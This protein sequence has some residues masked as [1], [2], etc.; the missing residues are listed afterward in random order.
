VL[1]RAI[2]PHR[3]GRRWLTALAA[4]SVV[5]GTLIATSSA[6]AVHDLDLFE[7]DKNAIDSPA[8]GADDWNNVYASISADANDTGD[9]DKCIALGAVECAFTADGV[10]TTIFTTGGSKD[11]IDI[12]SWRHTAGSVPDKDEILNA[13]AAKYVASG[14]AR[15]GHQILYFGAD[16]RAQNGSADF[17]FW[18]FRNPVGLN[19]DGT[20]SGTHT[21]TLATPGDILILGT[22]TQGGA[23]TNIRVFRW[24][25]TGGN[26]SGTIQ[27]PDADFQD[28][29]QDPPL[30]NDNGC[31]TVNNGVIPVAWPYTPKSG[32]AG[33]IPSGGFLEGGID[34][35]AIGL[36]GCFSSFV[37]ETRSSPSVT[38]TLKDFVLGNFEVCQT[39]LTTTP[40]DN[41]GTPIG[42]GGISI[43]SGSVQVR[44]SAMLVVNGVSTW[45]G[46]LETFLCGPIATGTC[47]TGGTSVGS[48]AVTQATTQ[49]ILSGPATIT[50]AGRY[51]WRG[52]FT[53]ATNGVPN[54]SDSSEGECFTVNPVTPSIATTASGPVLVGNPIS[55]S[56]TLSGTATQP[57][58]DPV[59]GTIVFRAYGPDDANCSGTAAFTSAT[60]PVSGNG[61]YSSGDFTPSLAGTYRWI[62]TYSG[63][64]PNTNPIAGVCNAANETSVVNPRQPTITTNASGANGVPLGTAISDSATLSGTAAGAGGTITFVAYGPNDAT[65]TT[66]A[67]TSAAIPVNGDG[68]YG[69]GDFTP[70][71]AGTYRWIATYSGDPPNTLGV[72]GVCNADNE[73]SLVI[74]LTPTVATGQFFYPNDAATVTV[75]SGGGNLAGSVRFRAYT[76]ADCSTAAIVDQ[77]V[78]LTVGG[79]GLTGTA[80]TTNTTVRVSTTSNLYWDVDYDSTNGAHEDVNG[81]CGTENSAITINNG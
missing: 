2:T 81:V 18:F 42:A 29:V 58:G 13:Y 50:S 60:I 56:A 55:D 27:G 70:T 3:R 21:G 25:G 73:A 10:G 34:L 54:A 64:P 20:F 33:S 4:L 80:E 30:T 11:H 8:G 61:P 67:F 26:E 47:T 9:D 66:V 78:A 57:D 38:A 39:T 19:A 49:P 71:A 15:D 79:T 22:F 12:P 63:D 41:S 40:T 62:A 52:E 28:C 65:C 48:V 77:T 53:S 74:S 32:A 24:V 36:G 59:G 69:S 6:L 43:G 7:L 72:A 51:C 23:A 75:A 14:G 16:R 35:T 45:S 68:T 76:T 31:G 1:S 37:G 17:G 5:A 46:S 44:D